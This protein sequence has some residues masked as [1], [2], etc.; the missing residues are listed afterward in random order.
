M[1]TH[2]RYRRSLYTQP[3]RSHKRYIGRIILFILALGILYLLS[4]GVMALFG[5]MSGGEDQAVALRI[6]SRSNV[7]VSYDEEDFQ[8]AEDGSSIQAGDAVR[9][10]ADSHAHLTFF[11]GTLV[12]LDEQTT[13]TVLESSDASKGAHIRMEI[14]EGTAWIMTPP[15]TEEKTNIREIESAR[16]A[17]GLSDGAE[18]VIGPRSVITYKA[19]GDGISVRAKDGDEEI[20]VGEGQQFTLP[21]NVESVANL[22][23]YR[24][25]HSLA[26]LRNTFAIQSRQLLTGN[27]DDGAL[28]E[29]SGPLVVLSPAEN[30]VVTESSVR[31]SGRV[32]AEVTSVRING[33][34]VVVDEADGSFV[35]DIALLSDTSFDIH[36]EA[37]DTSGKIISEITRTVRRESATASG[38]NLFA[39]PAVTEP[40]AT[41]NTYQ[42]TA[43]EVVLRGT[44]P[45]GA[46]QILVNDYSLRLFDPAKGT[47]SYLARLDLGNMKS[48]TNIY[49]VVAVNANGMRSA[50]ATI[51]INHGTA[52]TGTTSSAGT[53]ASTPSVTPQ[54]NVP[55]TPGVLKVTGPAAGTEY[56]AS[57]TGFL[58]EGTTS[59]QTD[60]IWVN[61][62]RLQLFVSGKTYWNYIAD[63]DLGN[64]KQGRNVYRI[65]ARN[66]DGQVLDTV[67]Y[68]VTYQP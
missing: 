38:T 20:F 60:S 66:K 56:A 22:E 53:A 44:A 52:T 51:T 34:E 57:G 21:E 31:V 41:G 63:V 33:Q 3:E 48:G 17:L 30:A 47:W 39:S 1:N 26:S 62:Y 5:L 42:T 65:I 45:E 11:D 8:A 36:V 7:D 19:S 67:D 25:G 43:E 6:E 15:S 64:L 54:N 4:K 16:L 9:T 55:L 32:E 28:E 13:V 58:L 46:T 68:V 12:R 59:N 23:R 35:D 2:Y 50:A 49:N 29:E 10:A 27:N 40:V 18:V 14:L 61:D 37:L 24:S